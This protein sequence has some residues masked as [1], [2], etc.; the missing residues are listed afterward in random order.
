MCVCLFVCVYFCATCPPRDTPFVCP[1]IAS[2]RIQSERACYQKQNPCHWPHSIKKFRPCG[3]ISSSSF[4][5]TIFNFYCIPL[6]PIR[7]GMG[8]GMGSEIEVGLLRFCQ[9]MPI[10]RVLVIF[11]VFWSFVGHFSTLFPFL[12]PFPFELWDRSS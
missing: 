1:A 11:A 5:F 7:R 4:A 12:V 8:W 9:I 3:A 2:P 10:F 6:A